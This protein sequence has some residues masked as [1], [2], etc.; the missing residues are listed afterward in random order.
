MFTV[1]N[2]SFSPQELIARFQTAGVGYC[3]FQ[4]EK[5]PTTG[6][7]HFQGYLE[8]KKPTHLSTIIN[9]FPHA[10][11]PHI[12]PRRG[13]RIQARN[14]CMKSDTR[15]SGSSHETGPFEVNEFGKGGQGKR[16]DLDAVAEMLTLG[17][18]KE[19]ILQSFPGTYMKFFKGIASAEALLNKPSGVIKDDFQVILLYGPPRTG[20]TSDARALLTQL[21]GDSEIPFVK[22]DGKWFDGYTGQ[23]GVIFDD[24]IG[25]EP[26]ITIRSV[27]SWFDSREI[28]VETKG[29][30]TTYKPNAIVVTTNKHPKLWFANLDP[31]LYAAL[32]SRFSA[33]YYYEAEGDELCPFIFR[34]ERVP[35]SGI[36]SRRIT[37]T[38]LSYGLMAAFCSNANFR[39]SNGSYVMPGPASAIADPSHIL[40][41]LH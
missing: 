14:Y 19:D 1:N 32:M 37:K 5:A 4:L 24:F 31:S 34:G 28:V 38:R 6:T 40:S 2:P 15:A 33:I 9:M 20:K 17:K 35:G 8:L 27:L 26:G 18:S 13:T 22:P 7:P 39:L 29:G 41:R 10:A 11:H 36:L 12:E 16:T 30:H 21:F 3:V 23:Q 25:E